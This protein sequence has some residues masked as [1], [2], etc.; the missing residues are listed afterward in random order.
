MAHFA[1][2]EQAN[3]VLGNKTSGNVQ[4]CQTVGLGPLVST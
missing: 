4:S 2:N 3:S 1:L